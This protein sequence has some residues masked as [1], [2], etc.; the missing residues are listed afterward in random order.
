MRRRP[1]I[2]TEITYLEMDPIVHTHTSIWTHKGRK[3]VLSMET[4][5]TDERLIVLM[6][7]ATLLDT[8]VPTYALRK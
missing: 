2:K 6:R 3:G 7:V 5:R 8:H 1:G 4:E